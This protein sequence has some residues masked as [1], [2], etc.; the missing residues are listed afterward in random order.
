MKW[1]QWR[2]EN[3]ELVRVFGD[4]NRVDIGVVVMAQIHPHSLRDWPFTLVITD[5]F[6]VVDCGHWPTLGEAKRWAE[7]YLNEGKSPLKPY[8][9]A[10][11]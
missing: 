4:E 10:K 7:K 1:H 2:D 5:G 8:V 3:G 6:M 9:K 11:K